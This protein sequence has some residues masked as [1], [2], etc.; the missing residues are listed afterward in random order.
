VRSRLEDAAV[1][2]LSCACRL[3][4]ART[5]GADAR[6][7]SRHAVLLQF[8]GLRHGL[9][10]G[11]ALAMLAF[12]FD[13]NRVAAQ[14][15]GA[16]PSD[17]EIAAAIERLTA[18]P[19]L[20]S[21]E[22]QRVLRWAD[23]DDDRPAEPPGWFDWIGELFSW[24]AQTSRVLVWLVLIVL[25]ALLVLAI[26]RFIQSSRGGAGERQ[27]R[28]D[29]PTH[30]RDLDIRPESLPDDIGAAAFA[31]WEAGERR[32]ALSLLYRGLLSRLVHEHSVPIRQS[33]TEGDCLALAA[34]HL[35]AD[36]TPYVTQ[37]VRVWQ[38]ATYGGR[39][40]ET[41]DVRLLCE[42]FATALARAGTRASGALT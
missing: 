40:P 39:E 7:G 10:V 3:G 9:L 34:R 19:N 29:V 24:L 41:T 31:H 17:A 28:V 33:T 1:H 27:R 15:A 22:Q 36:R 37:L 16:E 30:V 20:A 4:Y 6:S 23:S 2:P 26:V 35:Q 14:E 12:A 11:V 8:L 38:H 18:D 32:A 42:G 13:G 25:A 5:I 21:E